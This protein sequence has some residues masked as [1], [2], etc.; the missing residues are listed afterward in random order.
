M[1]A[2]ATAMA[3]ILG[4][5]VILTLTFL[6]V[7]FGLRRLFG[8]WEP[9]ADELFLCFYVGFGGTLVLLQIWHCFWSIDGRPAA[10]LLALGGAGHLLTKG[11][12]FRTTGRLVRHLR[13][14]FVLVLVTTAA[15]VSNQ[16]TAAPDFFDSGNYHFPVIR[17]VTTYPI[18][19]GLGN[20]DGHLGF[21]NASLLYQGMLE[22][23]FWWHRSAHIGNG[24]LVLIL[25][26]FG[27][28]K[29]YE[30]ATTRTLSCQ[31]LFAPL[32]L[33]AA[34]DLVESASTPSTDLPAV[35]VMLV[36]AYFLVGA[37]ETY[38]RQRVQVAP[39][40]GAFRVC[41]CALLCSV[42]LTIK[43][44]A[45]VYGIGAGLVF[46]ALWL[47]TSEVSVRYRIRVAAIGAGIAVGV[48]LLW[49]G[50]SVILTGYPF[51]PSL[52]MGFHVPWRIPDVYAEWYHWW[53]TTFARAPYR[54]YVSGQGWG[55][56]GSW[57]TVELRTAKIAG[58]LPLLLAIIC[59]IHLGSSEKGR[60]LLYHLLPA[61]LPLL[62]ALGAWFATAPSFRFGEGLMWIFAAQALATFIMK[63]ISDDPRRLRMVVGAVCLLPFSAIFMH[64]VLLKGS[65]HIG[66]LPAFE[67]TVWL[68]PGP[69]Y[70][71]REEAEPAVI[72]VRTEGGVVAYEPRLRPPFDDAHWR[73]GV[74]WYGAI[75]GAQRLKTTLRY[76][77][78]QSPGDGFEITETR[79]AWLAKHAAEVQAKSKDMNVRQLAFYFQVAPNTILQALRK[80]S[81]L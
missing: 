16:A 56:I 50:R 44:S 13:P 33:T 24:I 47:F 54:E 71:L 61:W 67:A 32:T 75:P 70:G 18:V 19:K 79:D 39:Q 26:L 58:L 8:T 74:M 2:E 59:L 52:A 36:I 64:A 41:A 7:G 46:L 42:A 45:A 4:S 17:W 81:H 62:L 21:N 10:I 11:A 57:F 31:V 73:E 68:P 28:Y 51:F 48:V 27:L 35:V 40:A 23:G 78:D 37:S 1:I 53:I 9:D 76:L 6:G 20:V 3:L 55:W 38:F 63:L 43:L 29:L 80:D 30:A 15:W 72:T 60:P 66:I 22:V 65:E 34:V 77:S 5:W 25:L 14:W 49:A 69:D 12:A